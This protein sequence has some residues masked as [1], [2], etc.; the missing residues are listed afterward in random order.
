M[1]YGAVF[2]ITV[3]YRYILKNIIHN[4]HCELKDSLKDIYGES[5]KKLNEIFIISEIGIIKKSHLLCEIGRQ[6]HYSILF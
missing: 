3:L 6:Q 4:T 1:D 2:L 5:N